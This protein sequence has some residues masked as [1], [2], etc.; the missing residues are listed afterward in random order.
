MKQNDGII[1]IPLPFFSPTPMHEG[2]RPKGCANKRNSIVNKSKLKPHRDDNKSFIKLL[3]RRV[4]DAINPCHKSKQRNVARN[5]MEAR[6]VNKSHNNDFVFINKKFASLQL[7]H[8]RQ[9]RRVCTILDRFVHSVLIF[10]GVISQQGETCISYRWKNK[11]SIALLLRN[12]RL[13]Q[14]IDIT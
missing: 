11:V 4:S 2:M 10:V 3:L 1:G 6:I 9:S 14:S 13:S 5:V 12:L 8:T 7:S